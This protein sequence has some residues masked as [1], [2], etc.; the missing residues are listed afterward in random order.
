MKKLVFL[1]LALL[2]IAVCAFAQGKAE[3]YSDSPA[4]NIDGF[5]PASITKYSNAAGSTK[6]LIPLATSVSK[7]CIQ[8]TAA[9]GVRLGTTGDQKAIAANTEWCRIVKRGITQL[10]YSSTTSGTVV[11]ERQF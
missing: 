2:A 7:V 1:T 5:A 8:P 10:Q 9:T 3:R 4:E 6:I 11:V